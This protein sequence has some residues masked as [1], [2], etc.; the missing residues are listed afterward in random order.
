MKWKVELN[1]RTSS[2]STLSKSFTDDPKIFKEN[3]EYFLWS[4]MFTEL[5]NVTEV[6]HTAEEIVRSIRNFGNMDSL[7][8]DNLETSC[9]H[10]IHEDGSEE[11]IVKLSAESGKV[12]GGSP[13]IRVGD[14]VYHPADQAFE[15]TQLA[16][17]D[18]K[19]SELVRLLDRGYN[20]VNLYRIYEFIQDNTQSENS[21]VDLGWW[22]K[23][24]ENQFKHTANS[25]KALGD[26]ARHAKE[27]IPSPEEPMTKSEAEKIIGRLV[28]NWLNHRAQSG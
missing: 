1:G 5:G 3:G 10:R 17:K 8:I 14:E 21:I 18:E 20:W 6:R 19:V 12:R 13:T 25:R 26:E 28:D 4:S 27:S 2:L 16:M 9:V 15:R 7:N 23:S 24:E 22:S 11:I